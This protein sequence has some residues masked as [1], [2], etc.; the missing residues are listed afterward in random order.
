[1]EEEAE[2]VRTVQSLFIIQN[3]KLARPKLTPTEPKAA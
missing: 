1:M 3:L 2:Q